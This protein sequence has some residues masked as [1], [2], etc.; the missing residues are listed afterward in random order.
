LSAA[1]VVA[2]AVLVV[3]NAVAPF[4]RG[5]WLVAYL[6]LVGGVSPVLLGVGQFRLAERAHV[7][8]GSSALLWAQ[9]ALWNGGALTVAAADMAVAPAGVTAGSVLLMAALCLFLTGSQRSRG[10]SHGPVG[11][12]D[13]SYVALLVFLAASVVVGTFLADAVP[14]Q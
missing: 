9:V 8:L 5:W 14:G 10:R 13:A 4:A 2:A 6:L 7:R 12:R 3:A 1:F 11:W